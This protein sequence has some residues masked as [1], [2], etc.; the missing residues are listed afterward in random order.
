MIRCY[1][2]YGG[3]HESRIGIP[4]LVYAPVMDENVAKW[5]VYAIPRMW[6]V[7]SGEL[8]I[9][10]NGEADSTDIETRNILPNLFFVSSDN[11]KNWEY[12][13]NGEKF[14]NEKVL[15]GAGRP[16][17][18]LKDGSFISVVSK[19]N[20]FPI[21]HTPFLKE[22]PN[23]QGGTI[24]RTYHY[25]DIMENSKGFY[26]VKHN[27][28]GEQKEK[29]ESK[30]DFQKREVNICAYTL[31]EDEIEND[32]IRL[33]SKE[34]YKKIPEYLQASVWDSAYIWE[35]KELD[36][37][38]LIAITSGQNPKVKDSY[39]GDLY[40]VE[41]KDNGKTWRKRGVIAN[42][43]EMEY[44]YGGDG[45][46]STLAVAKNGDLLCAMRMDLS[47]DPDI[48]T[49][50]C[51]T[52]VAISHDNGYTWD[53]PF[54]VSDSSV[55]PQ[56]FALK[57]GI[58]IVV[59]G[60]PGVHFKYSADTGKTWSESYSIIGKTLT[61]E[62]KTGRSDADIK[63]FDTSSYSNV[64]LEE[65]SEDTVIVC[66]N[67]MKYPDINGVNTKACFVRTIT[68]KNEKNDKKEN[69]NEIF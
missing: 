58:I 54:S 62:R 30:L 46:E 8:V 67:D 17:T 68:I 59:Y 11:G 2:K 37:G 12:K 32:R 6:R 38:N 50:L 18:K 56:I 42:G 24:L 19:E 48:A 41:S 55:T 14:Y 40:L 5:G 29:F 63:Y 31:S 35:I 9:R 36:D 49:P 52:M 10:F 43:K 22:F 15:V 4:V 20:C 64:F 25:S 57:N 1:K 53:K 51:D 66:Y 47:I 23:P 7:P 26:I 21:E 60:R 61:E 16:Y 27:S 65:I 34:C 28:S 33:K 13:E 44:G 39:C 69:E 45:F 3:N